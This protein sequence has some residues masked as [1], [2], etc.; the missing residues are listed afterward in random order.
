MFGTAAVSGD[1][2]FGIGQL[3]LIGAATSAVTLVLLVYERWAWRWPLLRRVA[4]STG[5]P[6]VHGTWRGTVQSREQDGSLAEPLD[7]YLVVR[8]DVLEPS[9]PNNVRALRLPVADGPDRRGN[10]R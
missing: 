1:S 2:S 7:C 10:A 3:R 9:D 4:E 5:T 8:Q 6:V